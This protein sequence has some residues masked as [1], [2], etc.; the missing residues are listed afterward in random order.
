MSHTWSLRPL[1]P[2]D[3]QAA[4]DFWLR[5]PGMGRSSADE[6]PALH[7]FLARNPGLSWLIEEDGQLAGTVLCGHDGRRGFIYHLAVA[8]GLQRQGVGRTLMTRAL[9]GLAREG[10]EKCH[11][12]VLADNRDGLGF[13]PTVGATERTDIVL[14][15]TATALALPAGS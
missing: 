6:V 11:L 10:I 7:R 5:T 2:R 4:A 14:F 12:M 13:W 3:C 9:A 15:S 8:P 1:E